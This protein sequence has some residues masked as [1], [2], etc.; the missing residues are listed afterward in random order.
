MYCDTYLVMAVA[1]M[2]KP[3][4]EPAKSGVTELLIKRLVAENIQ[5]VI[6]FIT[7]LLPTSKTHNVVGLK[8][9]NSI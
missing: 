3:F 4:T 7:K 5:L 2:V 1:V 6:C 9:K 8:V